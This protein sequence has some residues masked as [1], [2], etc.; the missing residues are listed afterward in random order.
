[1][2]FLSSDGS[3]D[4]CIHNSNCLWGM[5]FAT[6]PA[7]GSPNTCAG[8]HQTAHNSIFCLNGT[9]EINNTSQYTDE[10]S[11]SGDNPLLTPYV[12]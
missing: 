8:T 6:Q 9:L 5:E 11:P 3:T 10:K 12:S 4:N 2:S 1:M 7:A